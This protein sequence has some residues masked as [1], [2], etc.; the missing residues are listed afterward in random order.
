MLSLE[1][2]TIE[3]YYGTYNGNAVLLFTPFVSCWI[4]TYETVAGLTFSYSAIEHVI[5]VY[6]N[7]EFITLTQAYENGDLTLRNLRN[8]HAL[9]N[10]N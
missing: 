10:I 4:I 9:H 3:F 1:N 7:G 8:I 5:L 6:K 2:V